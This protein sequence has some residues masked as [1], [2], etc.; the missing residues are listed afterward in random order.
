VPTSDIFGN[1]Q[2][3]LRRYPR[4]PLCSRGHIRVTRQEDLEARDRAT[5]FDVSSMSSMTMTERVMELQIV[6]H[7]VKGT[8]RAVR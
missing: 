6:D 1:E 8:T 7:S 4:A 2:H 5:F 3:S